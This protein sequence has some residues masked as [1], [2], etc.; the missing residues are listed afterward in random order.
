MGPQFVALLYRQKDADFFASFC[1]RSSAWKLRP[2]RSPVFG[3]LSFWSEW[4]WLIQ[5][6]RSRKFATVDYLT[7]KS[8]TSHS[9]FANPARSNVAACDQWRRRSTTQGIQPANLQQRQARIFTSR[10]SPESGSGRY[11][12][13]PAGCCVAPAGTAA[14]CSRYCHADFAAASTVFIQLA[15]NDPRSPLPSNTGVFR[16]VAWIQDRFSEKACLWYSPHDV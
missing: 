9:F 6:Y 11:R 15:L 8:H 5:Y 7:I 13:S 16:L 3:G 14:D 4:S 2:H 1:C 12:P 10:K